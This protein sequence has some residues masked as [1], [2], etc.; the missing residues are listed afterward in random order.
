MKRKK[1][2][3]LKLSKAFLRDL[4]TPF[5]NMNDIVD[6]YSKNGDIIV[7]YRREVQENNP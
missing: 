6:I 7:E 4:L 2:E 1:V 5:Q 3:K